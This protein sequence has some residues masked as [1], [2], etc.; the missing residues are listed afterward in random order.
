[1]KCQFTRSRLGRTLATVV[2]LTAGVLVGTAGPAAA[3]TPPYELVSFDNGQC[4]DVY[5]GSYSDNASVRQEPCAHYSEQL[6]IIRLSPAGDALEFV[7]YRSDKCLDIPRWLYGGE[8][9]QNTCSH[10]ST[11]QWRY[12]TFP[13][14]TLPLPSPMNHIYQFVNVRSG[15]CL[16]VHGS[17][18]PLFQISCSGGYDQKWVVRA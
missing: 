8:T 7:N 6:W 17:G 12:T 1:M 4:A 2:A 3:A 15:L 18:Y 11:Q 13:N 16:Q 5:L 10:T 14:G 9:V